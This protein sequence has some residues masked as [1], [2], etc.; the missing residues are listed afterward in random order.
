MILFKER[1]RQD[2]LSGAKTTTLRDWKR[3]LAK[4][5][6]IAQ[7]NLG[8]PLFV[9][10][11]EAIQLDAID[12]NIAKA[13]GFESTAALMECLRGIYPVLPETL[14]LVRFRVAA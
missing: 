8:I 1:F 12:D 2:L 7:T 9:E 5:G 10:S 6:A 13:D 11:V 4:P 14:A 3:R